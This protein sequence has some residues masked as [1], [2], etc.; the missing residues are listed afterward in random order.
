VDPRT[1]LCVAPYHT[2]ADINYGSNHI[3]VDAL[4]D[5]DG[6]KMDGFLV[7]QWANCGKLPYPSSPGC[8]NFSIPLDD[9]SYHDYH[10][11]PNYWAYARHYVLQDHMFSSSLSY[12]GEQHLYLVS[13]WS[14]KCRTPNDV[15]SCTNARDT[16]PFLVDY[17]SNIPANQPRPS[18]AWTDITYLLHRA[19]VSWK[20]YVAPDTLADCAPGAATCMP[21]G[22]PPNG[23]P[24]YWNP[25]PYFSSVISDSQ[26][27][28]IQTTTNLDADLRNGTLP[29]VSWIAPGLQT[30]E[31]PP[32]SIS[33]GQ[34][35]VTTVVNSIMQ[36]SAWPSTTIFL[37][38]DEWGGFY[39]HVPPPTVDYNGY[40]LRVPGLVLS[41]YARRGYI[42]HQVLSFDAYLKFIED[43]FLHSQRLN[44]AT[45]GRPDPRMSVRENEPQLGDLTAEFDFTQTPNPPL[46]LAP[47]PTPVR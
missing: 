22:Q 33:E 31:H 34:A 13:A 29:A 25:L 36:S 12:S 14:A 47:Y 26:V 35:Y 19:G 45:D 32:G 2:S 21:T 30:S 9:M 24:Q 5:I 17:G 8:T 28:N 15:A 27:G 20:Y 38:W 39:D 40:G 23:T 46:I 6:G 11:I 42:D 4:T 37:A 3:S 7:D 16:S 18:Y 43:V 10:E 1:G 41:P 44:P